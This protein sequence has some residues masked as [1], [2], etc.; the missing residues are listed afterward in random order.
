MKK[1]I[2]KKVTVKKKTVKDA[3]IACGGTGISSKGS[4]CYPC[5]GGGKK[6]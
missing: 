3:C 6:K 4:R 2:K 1:G 5:S